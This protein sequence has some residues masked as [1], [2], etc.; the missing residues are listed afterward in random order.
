MLSVCRSSLSAPSPR[1]RSHQPRD[2]LLLLPIYPR[3]LP[4]PQLQARRDRTVL[5]R[6]IAFSSSRKENPFLPLEHSLEID[7]AYIGLPMASQTVGRQLSSLS[8][9]TRFSPMSRPVCR[10]LLSCTD[11][12]QREMST[13][14]VHARVVDT[15]DAVGRRTFRERQSY[16]DE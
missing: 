10:L 5:K 6:N 2:L 7:S 14:K 13:G 16:R 4:L 3:N 11:A 8:R 1:R 12:G 15:D 9:R